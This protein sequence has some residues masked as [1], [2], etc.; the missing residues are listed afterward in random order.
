MN[1]NLVMHHHREIS[2]S[3]RRLFVT[4][5]GGTTSQRALVCRTVADETLHIEPVDVAD[6]LAASDVWR[7]S[8]VLVW[9]EGDA[10]VDVA[11]Y[12]TDQG[13]WTPIVAI[14]T[15]PGAHQ[16]VR[17]LRAGALDYL[18]WPSDGAVVSRALH[19]AYEKEGELRSQ[20]GRQVAARHAFQK[21]SL[22]EQQVL[23]ALSQGRANKEIARDLCI[24][25]RTVEVHRANLMTKLDA[26]HSADAIR[27]ALEAS[28]PALPVLGTSNSTIPPL[29]Q[30][31][32]PLHPAPTPALARAFG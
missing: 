21:L 18:E 12:L 32:S 25:P 4:L 22:R 14:C 15:A 31:Y 9:D 7:T 20:K 26:R 17:A 16:I 30:V 8:V 2:V 29:A 5:V 11:R 3:N 23:S 13:C 19:A 27:I 6:E 28:L 24:S 10:V 1:E